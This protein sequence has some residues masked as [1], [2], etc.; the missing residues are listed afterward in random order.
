MRE[1]LRLPVFV[2]AALLPL[3]S[4]PGIYKYIDENGR[5][6]Y[7]DKPV[8]GAQAVK[9]QRAP[10]PSRED[11]AENDY[12]GE[13]NFDEYGE[14]TKYNALQV[15]HP[16]PEKVVN[17]RSGS[18]QVILLATPPLSDQHQLIITVDGKDISRGRHANLN[19]TNLPRGS[20][21]VNGRIVD[22]NGFEMIKSPTVTFYVR[23]VDRL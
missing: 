3:S 5:I 21:S 12:L 9:I 14:V 23:D 19:L 4:S 6:A 1:Y 2:L 7:S 13:D 15:L 17:E 22:S 16:I 20:H 8:V 11:V 10:T 18:V